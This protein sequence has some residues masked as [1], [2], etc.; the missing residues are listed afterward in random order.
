METNVGFMF[1]ETAISTAVLSFFGALACILAAV[2]LYGVLA[3]FVSQRRSEFGVRAALGA[4][5]G[6]LRRLVLRQSTR[7]TLIGMLLGILLS[8]GV[9]EGARIASSTG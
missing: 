5:P 9:R 8:V 3:T 2:G 7:L 1:S 4:T 6:D